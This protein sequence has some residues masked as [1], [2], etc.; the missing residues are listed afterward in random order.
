[1]ADRSSILNAVYAAAI[2]TNEALL[3]EN[4]LEAREDE[5]IIGEG[6]KIDSL[7]FVSLMVAV[8]RE[9]EAVAGACP[10]LVE[11]LS[12]PDAGVSTLGDLTDFIAARV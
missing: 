7:G 3:P 4:K 12:D 9:V 1:M 5:C 2:S 6:A 10:S 11:E 8:E